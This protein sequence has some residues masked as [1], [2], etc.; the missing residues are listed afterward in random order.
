MSH[1]VDYDHVVVVDNDDDDDDDAHDE[2]DE[3]E[4]DDDDGDDDNDGD[5]NKIHKEIL[6]MSMYNNSG[7][8]Y[9][10]LQNS[11]LGHPMTSVSGR[12]PVSAYLF[13]CICA[14][15]THVPD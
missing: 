6:L 11:Q 12:A 1:D 13:V 7:L 15:Y 9:L 14:N 3:D 8:L 10:V 5:D 4:D 2:D